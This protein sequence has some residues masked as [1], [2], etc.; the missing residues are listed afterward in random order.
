MSTLNFNKKIKVHH[1]TCVE[2]ILPTHFFSLLVL[3]VYTD[4]QFFVWYRTTVIS[5]HAY[6]IQT[7]NTI[8]LPLRSDYVLI[9]N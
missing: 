7:K 5:G 9:E 2:Q 6:Y 4:A 1:I 8:I 3:L